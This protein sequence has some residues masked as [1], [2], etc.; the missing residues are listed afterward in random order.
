[1]AAIPLTPGTGAL[2][3]DGNLTSDV[4]AATLMAK[5]ALDFV[6]LTALTADA[7]NTQNLATFT[8]EPQQLGALTIVDHGAAAEGNCILTVTVFISGAQK[9]VDVYRLPLSSMR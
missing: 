6:R 8:S 1:M 4:L 5:E 3:V 2:P 7:V 9:Q